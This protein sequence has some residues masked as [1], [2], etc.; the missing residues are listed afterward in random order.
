MAA[1]TKAES[2]RVL[3]EV[4]QDKVFWVNDGKVLK[5][6]SDL[7]IALKEMS[8]DTFRFHANTEK[9][10]F[11]KWV[12]EVVGDDRLARDLLRATSRLQAAK[13][14]STRIGAL[15]RAR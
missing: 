11:F 3:G 1:I 8:D 9:N 7:E 15:L 14:V 6:L 12:G 2:Q 5:K 13:A 10:D 4:P